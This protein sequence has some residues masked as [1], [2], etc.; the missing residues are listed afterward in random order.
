[1]IQNVSLLMQYTE[2]LSL[3]MNSL[4]I[5]LL[6]V[7]LFR[8][9]R[10]IKWMRKISENTKVPVCG[11]GMCDKKEKLSKEKTEQIQTK[12]L[13]NPQSQAELLSEVLDEVFP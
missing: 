12:G 6:L 13:E 11:Q 8:I 9:K 3:I 2:E 7:V 1:M 5:I 10:V 4:T